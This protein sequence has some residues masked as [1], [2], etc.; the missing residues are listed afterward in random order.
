[1]NDRS[2]AAWNGRQLVMLM[3][4]VLIVVMS[5]IGVAHSRYEARRLFVDLQH[6]QRE[7]DGLAVE[8]DRLQLEEGANSNHGLIEK[9][10]RERLN[11]ILPS[12]ESVEHVS[13]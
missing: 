4:L 2:L 9:K 7:R 8:W 13:P 6:L 3:A 5:A 12:F 1:M 10:A 11:M